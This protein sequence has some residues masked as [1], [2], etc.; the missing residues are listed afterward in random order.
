M[1]FLILITLVTLIIVSKLFIN[2]KLSKI[3]ILIYLLWWGLWLVLSN[4]NFYDLFLVEDFTYLLLLLNIVMFAGGFFYCGIF[5][6]RKKEIEI[7]SSYK[8]SQSKIFLLLSIIATLILMYYWT[9]Y[10]NAVNLNLSSDLRMERFE[11]GNVFSSTTE[12]FLFNYLMAPFVYISTII[13]AYLV[14]YYEVKNVI[15]ILL[16]LCIFFYAGIG[17]G[18]GPVADLLIAMLLLYFTKAYNL[19]YE[20]KIIEKKRS[21]RMQIMKRLLYLI[22]GLSLLIYMS[23]LTANRL[24]YFEFNIDAI[25]VGVK[26]FLDAVIIYYTGPFVALDYGLE[27][28][29]SRIDYLYGLGTFA[30]I[31]ELIGVAMTLLGV[32]YTYSNQPIGSLL[33]A[34]IINI[35]NNIG[36]NFAYTSVMIHYF[37]LGILG[38]IIFPF[39]FGFCVRKAIF[40]YEKK[41]TFPAL[42]IVVFLFTI[43]L[44]TIFKWSFQSPAAFIVLIICSCWHKFGFRNWR[45]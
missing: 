17:A 23:W 28:Y 34:N 38:V 14:I 24:G 16:S 7:F 31:D 5:K 4:L 33:Q 44:N 35:S 21:T 43:M 11:V 36:F 8:I 29:P 10:L 42:I 13:L 22:I 32:Q 45:S 37:D 2:D 41:P 27:A 20:N 19:G 1:I 3:I 30:G 9:R 26:A 39:M 6:H 40:L 12:I 18:R 15:F 25:E